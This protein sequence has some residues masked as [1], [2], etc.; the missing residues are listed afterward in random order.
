MISNHKGIASTAFS[1]LNLDV[2]GGS[3]MG[4]TTLGT[5]GPARVCASDSAIASDASFIVSIVDNVLS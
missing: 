5:G 2:I 4:S 1:T 3:G